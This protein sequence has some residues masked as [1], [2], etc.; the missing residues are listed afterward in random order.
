MVFLFFR[1]QEEVQRGVYDAVIHVGDFAYNMDSV[2]KKL[3][4]KVFPPSIG[5]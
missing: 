3:S 1:L 2:R 5:N 4:V